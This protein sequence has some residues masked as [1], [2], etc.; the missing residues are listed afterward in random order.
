MEVCYDVM[1][2]EIHRDY[3]VNGADLVLVAS[4]SALK[5]EGPMMTVL[6]ARSFENTVYTA[7]CNNCGEGP[8]GAYFGGSALFSPLGEKLVQ[9][10]KQEETVVFTISGKEIERARNTRHHLTDLRKDIEWL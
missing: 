6:P 3:A 4:A 8:A 7:Y 2:P 1:F 10:G 9:A 5:S